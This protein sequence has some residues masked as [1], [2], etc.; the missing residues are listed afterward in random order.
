MLTPA[1]FGTFFAA[2]NGG[3]QP[4]A[5]QQRLLDHVIT[6]G[7]WPRAIT[8]PT[9]TGKS[10]VVDVHVFANA[11]NAVGQGP[12][13]PRRLAVVVNRRAIVDQHLVHAAEI[14]QALDAPDRPEILAAVQA[15][16]AGLAEPLGSSHGDAPTLSVVSMRGGQPSL[17]E[18]EGV[19]RASSREWLDDPRRC[20][21]I[22]A[23]PDMWGSRLLFRGYGTAPLA[24]PRDAGLLALDAAV[25]VDEAHLSHQLLTTARDVSALSHAGAARLDVPALQVVSTTATATN[26]TPVGDQVVT[27]EARDIDGDGRDPELRRRLVGTKSI[28]RIISASQPASKKA[29]AA[30]VNEI[31]ERAAALRHEAGTARSDAACTIGVIVN[32]VATAAQVA[33]RLR[34][35]HG[36]TVVTWVGRMRPM[37]V[38]E[39]GAA[40]P[41]VF[42]VEGSPTVDALVTSQTA[43][44]GVDLDLAGMVTELAPASALVQRFGRVNRRGRRTDAV[45]EVMVPPAPPSTDRMPYLRDDLVASYVWLQEIAARG[46]DA[47]PW[48]LS[49]PTAPPLPV[50]KPSRLAWSRVRPSDADL[51]SSTSLP[52][53]QEPDLAFWLRDDLTAETA[54]VGVVVRTLP[55][56]D[57][58]AAALIVATL[59]VDREILPATITTARAVLERLIGSGRDDHERIF[60]VAADGKTASPQ[61][62]GD[63]ISTQLTPGAMVVVDADHRLVLE[64]VLVDDVPGRLARLKPLE[65]HPEYVVLGGADAEDLLAVTDGE[66]QDELA[67]E[68]LGMPSTVA[69]SFDTEGDDAWVVLVPKDAVLKDESI[70][71]ELTASSQGVHLEDHCRDVAERAQRLGIDLG[72]PGDLLAVLYAA[73]I[74]HDAGKRDRRFQKYRL[75][76]T[77]GPLL[78]KS[79]Q[80]PAWKVR[81]E[82]GGLPPAW[83]HEQLSA[84]LAW[85]AL[86]GDLDESRRVLVARLAG[87]SHGWG[88][89]FFPHGSVGL[90]D[91]TE[92]PG[93]LAASR[94]LFDSTAWHDVIETTEALY[95]IWGCAYLEALVRA[96]DGTVSKEGH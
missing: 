33:D 6:E 70:R 13:V 30:Y 10:N 31:A 15:A 67:S 19:Q 55:I 86:S 36:L 85:L 17:L 37:D 72:L 52:L 22:C 44:V 74:W 34:K 94:A 64:G 2:V 92:L 40:Y 4:F 14:Q 66:E 61:R 77:T 8:A 39:M 89:P 82:R 96:A 3:Y 45:V 91:D 62:D 50:T 83:R 59:P 21:V 29:G 79:S 47:S 7:V 60:L 75:L 90:A 93:S 95:G 1:A 11:L 73:G 48:G 25:I 78:A 9:G 26:S 71:Q 63:A 65:D 24:R 38:E 46:G 42:T 43:E 5:W 80:R 28:K 20:M 81:R 57:A 12:R 76:N 53:F 84:A 18:P 58:S 69:A 16:L 41:G 23:T 27:V 87:T 49:G 32:H 56:D 68:R 54:M 88:R 35:F 51:L